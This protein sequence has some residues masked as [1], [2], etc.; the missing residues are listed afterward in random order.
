MR[1]QGATVQTSI[2]DPSSPSRSSNTGATGTID[3]DYDGAEPPRRPRASETFGG[4]GGPSLGMLVFTG[5]VVVLLVAGI[6]GLVRGGSDQAARFMLGPIKLGRT[7]VKSFNELDF[8]VRFAYPKEF[9]PVQVRIGSS[10]GA[11]PAAQKAIGLKGENVIIVTRYNLQR[12]VTKSNM[13]D[14]RPEADKLFSQ[15]AGKQVKAEE[16]TVAGLPALRY[17]PFDLA[18]IKGGQSRLLVVFDGVTEYL[19]NCQSTADQRKLVNEGCDMVHSSLRKA[20]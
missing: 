9:K 17:E 13:K 3:D 16:A 19:I 18:Q 20:T 7:G 15:L 1:A 10:A 2:M 14:I 12:R 11:R 8:A 5:I 4:R 6:T